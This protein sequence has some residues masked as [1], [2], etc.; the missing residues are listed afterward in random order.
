LTVEDEDTGDR[1]AR[2]KRNWIGNVTI[3]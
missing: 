3:T 1:L 2:R